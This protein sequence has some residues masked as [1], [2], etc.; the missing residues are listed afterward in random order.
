M[1]EGIFTE[2]PRFC[3]LEDTAIAVGEPGGGCR[4]QWVR[5]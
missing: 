1:T 2:P 3:N 4:D 5:S